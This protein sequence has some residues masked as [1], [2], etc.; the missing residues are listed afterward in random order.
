MRKTFIRTKYY[1]GSHIQV[2]YLILLM[3]SM[4]LP[5]ILV[6]ACLYYLMFTIMAE[7]LGIPE[8]IAYN[9]MPVLEKI[10][11]MLLVSV[12]PIFLILIIWGVVLSHRF[13]GP[14]ERLEAELKS[15]YHSGDYSKRIR[16][17]K[18]DDIR[19]IADV[20]NKLL[21]KLEG[22]NK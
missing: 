7:Q 11:L 12:P 14:L 1:T 3:A 17:R 15:V 18:G 21:D 6:G 9:L 13:A 2:H 16:L 19:P 4:I 5:L 8:Y 20:V 22:H 10:N